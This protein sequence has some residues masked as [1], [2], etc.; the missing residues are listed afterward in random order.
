MTDVD[1][2]RPVEGDPPINA[3]SLVEVA[4]EA[5]K[6]AIAQR[7]AAVKVM[8]IYAIRAIIDGYNPKEVAE[9]C[10]F[11]PDHNRHYRRSQNPVEAMMRQ[12][13]PG[14][15]FEQI[16]MEAQPDGPEAFARWLAE[17][18]IDLVREGWE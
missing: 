5:R 7:E 4:E 10:G 15:Y 3:M 13:M 17:Y 12:M 16:E 8:G 1:P 6:R 18:L 9:A 11:D 2:D 14:V